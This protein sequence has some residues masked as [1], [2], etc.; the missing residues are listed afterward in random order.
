METDPLEIHHVVIKR[1]V[2]EDDTEGTQVDPLPVVIKSEVFEDAGDGTEVEPAPIVNKNERREDTSDGFEV[3][4]TPFTDNLNVSGNDIDISGSS[5]ISS[6]NEMRLVSNTDWDM[7][8]CC[9]ICAQKSSDLIS[10]FGEE[11]LFRQ[12]TLKLRHCLQ[13]IVSTCCFC[14]FENDSVQQEV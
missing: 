11:G 6:T 14:R 5:S 7:N 10:I 13:I 4:Q 3:K 9:R 1:E 2:Y 12:L 8:Q